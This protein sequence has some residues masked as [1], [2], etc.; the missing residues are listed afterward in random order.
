MERVFWIFSP[1]IFSDEV[2]DNRFFCNSL[3]CWSTRE[4]RIFTRRMGNDKAVFFYIL[5]PRDTS[6]K[7]KKFIKTSDIFLLC[8]FYIDFISNSWPEIQIYKGFLAILDTNLFILNFFYRITKYFDFF[9]CET[10]KPERT[11]EN[12]I[13]KRKIKRYK[14]M[15]F[16]LAMF[17]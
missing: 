5:L 2:F 3:N 8:E 9:F 13:H 7:V 16:L 10:F 1:Y 4:S 14:T 17:D 6:N 12:K 15:C 11:S